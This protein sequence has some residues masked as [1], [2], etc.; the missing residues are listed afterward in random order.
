MKTMNSVI[1]IFAMF[2]FGFGFA[3]YLSVGNYSAAYWVIVAAVW[4]LFCLVWKRMS[5]RSL[6]IA[7]ET[8]ELLD[9][10]NDLSKG[11]ADTARKVLQTAEKFERDNNWLKSYVKNLEAKIVS[12]KSS[13]AHLNSVIDKKNKEIEAVKVAVPKKVTKKGVKETKDGDTK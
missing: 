13:T 5:D 4:Y 7:N 8:L 2:L 3:F 1:D 12:Y 11:V 9:M 10:Q 6:D